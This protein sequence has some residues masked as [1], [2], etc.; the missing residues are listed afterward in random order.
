MKKHTNIKELL[1]ELV[2]RD[3]H[4]AGYLTGF[5]VLGI[6]EATLG[7]TYILTYESPKKDIFLIFDPWTEIL[8]IR[9]EAQGTT[10]QFHIKQVLKPLIDL[11]GIPRLGRIKKFETNIPLKNAPSNRQ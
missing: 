9:D 7:R 5:K 10:Y 11:Y 3:P 6:D 8:T 4:I 2:A 1:K